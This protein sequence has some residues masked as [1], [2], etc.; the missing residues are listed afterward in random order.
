MKSER[1]S[2]IFF[3]SALALSPWLGGRIPLGADPIAPDEW[4]YRIFVERMVPSIGQALIAFLVLCGIFSAVY[5]RRVLPLPA[6]FLTVSL[7]ALWGLLGLSLFFTSFPHES[8]LEFPRWTIYVFVLFLSIFCLGRGEGTTLA[9]QVLGISIFIVSVDGVREYITSGVSNWRI[10]AGWQNPNALASVLALSLPALLALSIIRTGESLSKIVAY[11][12]GLAVILCALWLTQSK[13]GLLSALVGLIVFGIFAI[14]E[15]F[16]TRKFPWGNFARVS[17]V[18]GVIL[19]VLLFL[20]YIPVG[21]GKEPTM[22]I[23]T[24]SQEGEQSV[25]YRIKLWQE[26]FDM[27]K[28]LPFAGGGIGT[29]A[30]MNPRYFSIPGSR[31]AHNAYLQMAAEAGFFALAMMLLFGL[32]WLTYVGQ[33][34]RAVSWENN[35]L[36]CGIL[37]SIAAGGANGLVE[38]SFSYFGFSVIFFTLLGLGLLLSADGVRPEQWSKLVQMFVFVLIPLGAFLY[39]LTSATAEG[40]VADG[41]YRFANDRDSAYSRFEFASKISPLNPIPLLTAGKSLLFEAHETGSRSKAK[42][43]LSYFERLV[44]LRPSSASFSWLAEAQILA[45]EK[46]KAMES[47]RRAIELSPHNPRYRADFF[48][49]L[50]NEGYTANARKEAEEIVKME[51]SEY[52]RYNALPWLVNTDTLPARLYLAEIAREQGDA[53][54]EIEMLEGAFR[55]LADYR[56]KTYTELM[57]ITGGDLSLAPRI[58]AS[59]TPEKIQELYAE[60]LS[61]SERLIELYRSEGNDKKAD[62]IRSEVEKLK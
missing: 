32:G 29:F 3:L 23:A 26:T 44:K 35:F 18:S 14:G 39:L 34:H 53:R 36:R 9:L 16:R 13:G 45:G 28:Q 24:A 58:L 61:V 42:Q 51:N 20:V 10:F 40:F 60:L 6:P 57:R 30:E 55:I 41:L 5:K 56:K 17:V 22:R 19:G 43:A 25:G 59:E 21:E 7:F 12:F 2:T 1:R 46:T 4:F 50:K 37:G 52:F 15:A 31:L 33:P 54:R 27:I 38:S 62:E 49:F 47:F 48:L 8:L 11:S